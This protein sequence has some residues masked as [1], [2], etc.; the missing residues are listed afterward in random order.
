MWDF[1]CWPLEIS[2]QLFFFSFLFSTN[3]CSVDS[4]FAFFFFLVPVTSLYS[5]VILSMYRLYLHCW[6]VFF[7]LLFFAHSVCPRHLWDVRP[8]A[9]LWV[10]L[11]SYPFF[12]VLF[13]YTLK[14][15]L[16]CYTTTQNRRLQHHSSTVPL[17]CFLGNS[18]QETHVTI[19]F[20]IVYEYSTTF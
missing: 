14:R 17:K 4:W 5:L 10:F 2:V 18:S 20:L 6:R 19:R 13:S 3:C 8:Y 7:L 11:F 1:A 15:I 16:Q 9:S 12:E